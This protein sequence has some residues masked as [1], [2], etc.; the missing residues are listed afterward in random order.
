M[1]TNGPDTDSGGQ[2]PEQ[3]ERQ[4]LE[5]LA[6]AALDEQRKARRWG[7]FFKL[8]IAGYLLIL[9]LLSQAEFGRMGLT[10]RHTALVNLE[11]VIEADGEA[12]ADSVITGLRAAFEDKA[13]VGVILRA[14]SPGGSP[15]QAAYINDEIQRL[16]DKHPE[17]PLYAVIGDT[18]ASGC[19]Y[20]VASA[21]K[22]YA[23]QASIVGSIGVLM[24][25]FGFEGTMQ[26]LGVERRL[27][28][29]GEHKGILDPFSPLDAKS[30]RHA[31]A[32]LDD[33]HRQF[34]EVV[35]RGRGDALKGGKELFSGLFWTGEKAKELGLIDEF[36][37]A[38]QVAREV[39]GAEDIVDYTVQPQF[40]DRF[41]KRLGASMARVVAGE[42]LGKGG[43]AL[44]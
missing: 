40:F 43:S 14:N 36:G 28:T 2:R 11:G 8:F 22:I 17:I 4:T 32:V 24:D 38:G 21:D 29:A 13:T 33:I 7:I 39:I 23:N 42:W 15:V 37:S 41:A 3:W 34:I 44:R 18:C 16:R 26:K 9:L 35:K 27:L 30:R 19:Y 5:K 12:N 25:G 6:F 20:A 10:G 1:T 31:Q